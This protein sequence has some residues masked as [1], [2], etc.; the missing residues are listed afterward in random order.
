MLLKF[1]ITLAS[2]A[3]CACFENVV[4]YVVDNKSLQIVEW[5][6]AIVRHCES[7]SEKLK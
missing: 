4:S 1:L 5:S 3:L 2:I 7:S 6:K